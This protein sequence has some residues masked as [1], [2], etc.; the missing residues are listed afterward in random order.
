VLVESEPIGPDGVSFSMLSRTGIRP[1]LS[2]IVFVV[3]AAARASSPDSIESRNSIEKERY[4]KRLLLPHA[5]L[6]NPCLV[7]HHERLRPRRTIDE[8]YRQ[9]GAFVD[10]G[11]KVESWRRGHLQYVVWPDIPLVTVSDER[12]TLCELED[13]EEP[14]APRSGFMVKMHPANALVE[15]DF[16]DLDGDGSV[17]R[18]ERWIKE[19]EFYQIHSWR[20]ERFEGNIQWIQEADRRRP[21]GQ[22]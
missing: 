22:P 11:A 5:L 14:R 2:L 10:N 6:Q 19:N 3:C 9:G 20:I 21:T 16:L 13:Y 15:D 7:P 4:A 8:V 17:D 18:V 12:E 1:T